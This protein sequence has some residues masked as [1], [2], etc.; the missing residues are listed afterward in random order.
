MSNKIFLTLIGLLAL[1]CYADDTVFDGNQQE[2]TSDSTNPFTTGACSLIMSPNPCLAQEQSTMLQYAPPAPFIA[3]TIGQIPAE[4]FP[5][6]VTWPNAPS[7]DFSGNNPNGN[8]T[9]DTNN[10][11]LDDTTN[12]SGRKNFWRNEQ[13]DIPPDETDHGGT[14]Q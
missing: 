9:P 6:G 7:S 4:V 1:P 5:N 13:Q 12:N 11:G 14:F 10:T 2:I 3:T 8:N